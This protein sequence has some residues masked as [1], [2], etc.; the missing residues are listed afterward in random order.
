MIPGALEQELG[1]GLAE[2][3]RVVA[4]EETAGTVYLVLPFVST[5]AQEVGELSDRDLEAVTG[6]ESD[7]TLDMTCPVNIY[8]GTNVLGRIWAR[9]GPGLHNPDP[10]RCATVTRLYR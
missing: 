7:T 1:S 9:K 5:D 2:G 6:G 4:V 10:V 8:C 3:V